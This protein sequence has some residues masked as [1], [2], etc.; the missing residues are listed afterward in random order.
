M[1]KYS[2][3][4]PQPAK[5]IPFR[6][7]FKIHPSI[8]SKNELFFVSLARQIDSGVKKGYRENKIVDFV[9]QAVH[10]Y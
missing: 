2:L 9:V 7:K 4:S 3:Y 6:K 1:S 8:K 5:L 10:K